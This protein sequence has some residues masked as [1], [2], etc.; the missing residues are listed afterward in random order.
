M[1]ASMV[2]KWVDPWGEKWAVTMAASKVDLWA[3]SK[4]ALTADWMVDQRVEW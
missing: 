4:V 1:V 3:G 2:A